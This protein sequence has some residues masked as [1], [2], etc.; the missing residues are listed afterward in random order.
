MSKPLIVASL[1][2]LACSST[3][4]AAPETRPTPA[5][6]PPPMTCLVATIDTHVLFQIDHR[7][8]EPR[9]NATSTLTLYTNGAWTFSEQRGDKVTRT[10]HGCLDARQVSAMKTAL[11]SASWKT[12][13]ADATCAAWSPN[14]TEYRFNTKLVLSRRLCD[15]V[16]LDAKSEQAL[17]DATKIVNALPPKA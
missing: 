9:Y 11:A 13:R 12:T 2:T 15:A 5:P 1:F 6:A 8:E 7:S 14:Y 16:I 3:A 17:A 4:I 10:G